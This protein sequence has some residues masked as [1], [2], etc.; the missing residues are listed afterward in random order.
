M[1]RAAALLLSLLALAACSTTTDR[2]I[3]GEQEH[4]ADRIA[5][6]A[7][8]SRERADPSGVVRVRDGFWFGNRTSPARLGDPLPERLHDASTIRVFVPANT[9]RSRQDLYDALVSNLPYQLVIDPV[10][11]ALLDAEEGS[12]EAADGASRPGATVPPA[13]GGASPDRAGAAFFTDLDGLYEGSFLEGDLASPF[14]FEGTVLSLIGRVSRRLGFVGWYYESGRVILYVHQRRDFEFQVFPEDSVFW[15]E[16]ETLVRQ[17]CGECAVSVLP[18][19]ARISL[20]AQPFVLQRVGDALDRLNRRMTESL[21]VDVQ[22]YTLRKTTSDEF[23]FNLNAVLSDAV[24]VGTLPSGESE[25]G[26][27][28]G[29]GG[30]RGRGWG[31]RT[32]RPS[33]G[34]PRSSSWARWP[35]SCPAG[36]SPAPA[37][38]SSSMPCPASRTT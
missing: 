19:L 12:G 28:G 7:A 5:A 14:H 15:S 13:P 38:S 10:S 4:V 8:R 25:E 16:A 11:R 21:L 24:R 18:N 35:P 34:C 30:Y 29:R 32:P 6:D 33:P 9:G 36:R 37:G 3:R 2:A 27:G 23:S 1:V 22:L 26:V 17:L 20:V 31:A